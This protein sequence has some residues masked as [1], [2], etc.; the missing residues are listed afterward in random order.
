MDDRTRL[1]SEWVDQPP[2][3]PLVQYLRDA[4]RRAVLETL[5]SPTHVLDIASETGVTRAL[6]DDAAVT[7]VDFSPEASARERETLDGVETFAST[8]PESPTLPFGRSR[9]DAAVCVGPLDWR[10]LDADHLSREVSRVLTRG[11]PSPSPP[12]RPN[13]PTTSAVATNSPTGPPTSSRACWPRISTPTT[14]R[15][16]TSRPRRCSGSRAPSRLASNGGS[17]TTRNA[18]RRPAPVTAPATSSPGRPRRATAPDWTTRST[19]SFVRS[20]SRGSSTPR[21]T[22]FTADATTR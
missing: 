1:L 17:P 15:T 11:G 12:R 14:R 21:P 16:S 9:F 18:G 2:A 7:R 5:D 13:P 20:P 3:G 6:P 19:V 4:E 8:T 22:A 10:F